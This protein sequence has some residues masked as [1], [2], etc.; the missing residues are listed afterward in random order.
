MSVWITL[1]LLSLLI[2]GCVA[3]NDYDLDGYDLPDYEAEEDEIDCPSGEE[4]WLQQKQVPWGTP[5]RALLTLPPGVRIA[6]SLIPGAGNGI[7]ATTF[8]PKYT[9]LGE[10]EGEIVTDADQISDYAWL[11]Y[12]NGAVE[13][14]VDAYDESTSS[15]VRWINCARHVKEEHVKFHEC[16]GKVFY[17]TYKDIHPGQELLVYYGIVYARDQLDIDV[18]NFANEAVDIELYKHLAC[19]NIRT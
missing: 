8:I 6:Q 15:W 18:D 11:L 4:N 7:F 16:R 12:R 3:D 10:Y 2:A 13:Y 17:V 9:W 1:F 14:H 5:N 19:W